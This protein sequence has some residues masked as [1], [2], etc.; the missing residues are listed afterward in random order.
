MQ[1]ASRKKKNNNFNTISKVFQTYMLYCF[2]HSNEKLVI[3]DFGVPDLESYKTE[4]SHCSWMINFPFA[5]HLPSIS[6]R[7]RGFASIVSKLIRFDMRLFDTRKLQLR[8]LGHGRHGFIAR[9]CNYSTLSWIEYPLSFDAQSSEFF[10]LRPFKM[11]IYK[12]PVYT[13]FINYISIYY[14]KGIIIWRLII[15]MYDIKNWKVD[16]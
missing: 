5:R 6:R 7:R 16:E 11:R 2:V 13:F 14:L 9:C 10:F 4:L 8:D 15:K 3:D 12:R 1:S